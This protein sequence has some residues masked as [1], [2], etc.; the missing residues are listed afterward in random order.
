MMPSPSCRTG[1]KRNSSL[2]HRCPDL[3][4]AAGT[5]STLEERVPTGLLPAISV[6]SSIR[7]LNVMLR[8]SS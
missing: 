4:M 8:M 5:T 6:L 7:G 2:S 3:G 1:W